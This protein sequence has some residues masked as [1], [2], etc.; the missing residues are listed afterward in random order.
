MDNAFSTVPLFR[1]LRKISI[2]AVGTTRINSAELPNLLKDKTMTAWNSLTGCIATT[3]KTRTGGGEFQSGEDVLCLRWKDNN[4][5]RLLT[6][7]HYWNEYTLSE[8]RK[9]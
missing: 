4:I 2:R 8:R 1:E 7:V 9:P 3:P 6:T 5:V